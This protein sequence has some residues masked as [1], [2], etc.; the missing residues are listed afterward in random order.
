[1]TVARDEAVLGRIRLLRSHGM[2]TTSWDRFRGH[3]FDYDVVALGL[4]YRP[5]ELAAAIGRAQLMKLPENNARRRVLLDRYGE[6]L[7]ALAGVEPASMREGGT[8]H[9]AVAIARDS[10]TRDRIRAALTEARIQT[11]LHYPPIHLFGEFRSS[12]GYALGD[13]PVA[14]DLA[15]RIVTL[16]LYS[17]MTVTQ[18]DK[19]CD[20]IEASLAGDPAAPALKAQ[21]SHP[22]A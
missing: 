10:D 8:S 11:S 18:V 16:P 2:T 5:T 3:A 4:N 6:R 21:P 22:P 19:V 13:L 14:E 17:R 9:L 20:A 7:S 12:Y 15:A 1:M